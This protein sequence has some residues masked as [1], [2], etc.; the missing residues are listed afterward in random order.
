M[1]APP[2]KKE[3]G[4]ARN[5]DPN[6]QIARGTYHAFRAKSK[7]AYIRQLTPLEYLRLP[8]AHQECLVRLEYKDNITRVQ[9]H[10]L[11]TNQNGGPA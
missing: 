5:P 4:P 3:R 8:S 6:L 1:N 2:E 7:G 10:V 9:G 11:S